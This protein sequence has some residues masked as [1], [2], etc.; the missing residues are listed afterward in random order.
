MM[1]AQTVN[2]KRF[3]W[4]KIVGQIAKGQVK[5]I[6]AQGMG[7]H[8]VP[9]VV[10]FVQKTIQAISDFLGDKK[11]MMGDKLTELDCSLF[12]FLYFVQYA[13]HEGS[14][15][16]DGTGIEKHE[17][18]INYVDNILQEYFPDKDELIAEGKKDFMEFMGKES[19]V[20]KPKEI[21]KT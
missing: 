13:P 15:L 8:T 5:N 16:Y 1:P 6:K 4:R 10:A 21:L 19:S 3:I 2:M 11:Y 14:P 12:G 18:I 9:E 7:M 17:N 20:V